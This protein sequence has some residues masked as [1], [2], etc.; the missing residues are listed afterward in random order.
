MKNQLKRKFW[1]GYPCRHLAKNFGQA[2]KIL[3]KKPSVSTR[4][5]CADVH[6]K[7]SVL[8]RGNLKCDTPFKS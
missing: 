7:S 5:S 6:A 3:G 2:M 4:P 8:P 1:A